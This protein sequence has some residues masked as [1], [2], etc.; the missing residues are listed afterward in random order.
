MLPSQV[1]QDERIEVNIG[2]H[3]D[4]VRLV[5]C[6]SGNGTR[7]L[8]SCAHRVHFSYF[9]VATHYRVSLTPFVGSRAI[10]AG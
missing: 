8:Q 3:S 5:G 4:G 6:Q 10:I 2:I 9:P 7:R 1:H